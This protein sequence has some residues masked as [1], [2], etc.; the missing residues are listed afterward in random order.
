[1]S[2]RFE[3][4]YHEEEPNERSAE[5]HVVEWTHVSADGKSKHGSKVKAFPD[6]CIG[7]EMANELAYVLNREHSFGEFA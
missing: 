3:A 4:V 1:M 7:G 5:W 6:T 2:N